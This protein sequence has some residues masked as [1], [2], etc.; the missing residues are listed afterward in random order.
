MANGIVIKS[1]AVWKG[2]LELKGIHME[3]EFE[4]FDCGRGWKFLFGKLLLRCFQ[5]VHDYDT[6]TVSIQSKHGTAIL[7]SNNAQEALTAPAGKSLT[8]DAEQRENLVGGSSGAKPPSRQVLH[9]DSVDSLVQNDK[10]SFVSG[11]VDITM[12]ETGEDVVAMNEDFL[13]EKE[14]SR[15]EKNGLPT[16]SR[17]EV[18]CEGVQES[19]YYIKEHGE[20]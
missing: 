17:L 3:G 15:A 14:C 16:E 8:L 20:G 9:M 7:H 10:S 6:D 11:C 18:A 12:K 2:T 19:V 4:V 5:G 13:Q 1:Q